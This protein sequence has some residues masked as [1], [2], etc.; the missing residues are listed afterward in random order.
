MSAP[1]PVLFYSRHCPHSGELL[2]M[3]PPPLRAA[4]LL[5]CVDHL[6]PASVP[7]CVRGVPCLLTP[8]QR[9]VDGPALFHLVQ[10]QAQAPQPPPPDP[11]GLLSTGEGA[12]AW[13]YV[14]G[15]AATGGETSATSAFITADARGEFA[16][17]RILC[18]PDDSVRR[19][20]DSGGPGGDAGG[21]IG[22]L[23][24]ARE[25]ERSRWWG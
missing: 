15:A 20:V 25:R 1:P 3:L 2:A 8:D 9:V 7:A 13:A 22:A 11:V 23:E 6:P 12:G 24:A 17:P 14:E 21:E 4:V 5:L 19:P 16:F 10:A 18:P